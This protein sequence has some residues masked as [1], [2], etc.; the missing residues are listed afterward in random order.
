MSL[1]CVRKWRRRLSWQHL[2]FG[3][4]MWGLVAVLGPIIDLRSNEPPNTP[5][6][7]HKL[8]EC[9][10]WQSPSGQRMQCCG[11]DVASR[12]CIINDAVL[13]INPRKNAKLW[14]SLSGGQWLA[15][16][17]ADDFSVLCSVDSLPSTDRWSQRWDCLPEL[18]NV[19]KSPSPQCQITH[20]TDLLIIFGRLG[21]TNS[22]HSL[23]E[24][25]LPLYDMYMH[26]IEQ[27][28]QSGSGR[29]PTVTLA[30]HDQD[31]E[32]TETLD[33]FH[34]LGTLF[35]RW[36]IISTKNVSQTTCVL[37]FRT[38]IGTKSQCI[39]PKHCKTAPTTAAY[40][41]FRNFVRR[42]V[43]W[44]EERLDTR[45]APRILLVQRT[46]QS[47]IVDNIVE[48]AN[49]IARTTLIK[50]SIV[51][52]DTL[53][54]TQQAKMSSTADIFIFVHGAALSLSLFLPRGAVIIEIRMHMF[55]KF[56]DN[57]IVSSVA[58]A[59]GL[60]HVHYCVESAV[61]SH[62]E[63]FGTGPHCTAITQNQGLAFFNA[64]FLTIDPQQFAGV[65]ASSIK[66]WK[67]AASHPLSS[68]SRPIVSM[69]IVQ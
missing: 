44:F 65:V 7:Q 17:M 50:P 12:R 9:T 63:M 53:S 62:S 55:D 25:M 52:L 43:Q 51:F 1:R 24:N 34:H 57:G 29:V 39:H 27:R 6:S 56:V 35:P 5:W 38:V 26:F 23:Y 54:F 40:L 46:K 4:G 13:E 49:T 8:L 60:M 45:E 20:H 41:E 3:I 10:R 21:S 66:M 42:Q 64:K 48:V 28:E 18:F 68:F 30:L 58:Q 11:G 19:S 22:H 2:F 67:T 47:R 69:E 32:A 37:A 31:R 36:S 16:R 61:R 15:P 33:P 59:N 14:R